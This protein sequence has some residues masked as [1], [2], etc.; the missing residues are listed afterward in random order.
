MPCCR[1]IKVV[2]G[3]TTGTAVLQT[4]KHLFSEH[5]KPDYN[6]NGSGITKEVNTIETKQKV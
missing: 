5:K 6:I 4:G 2:F 1:D 3:N